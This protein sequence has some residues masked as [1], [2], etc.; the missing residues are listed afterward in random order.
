M[1]ILCFGTL[2]YIAGT[3]FHPE[4]FFS[5]K[6][7]FNQNVTHNQVTMPKHTLIRLESI[8]MA[9]SITFHTFLRYFFYILKP[10]VKSCWTKTWCYNW[11]HI[12]RIT[13]FIT[14]NTMYLMWLQYQLMYHKTTYP[15]PWAEGDGKFA[16]PA[17][18][19]QL[20]T[21]ISEGRRR[22]KQQTIRLHGTK[23]QG[24]ILRLRERLLGQRHHDILGLVKWQC[25]RSCIKHRPKCQHRHQCLTL[26]QC[27]T[28]TVSLSLYLATGDITMFIAVN[29]IKYNYIYRVHFYTHNCLPTIF[30][31]N[32]TLFASLRWLYSCQ[33]N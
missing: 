10:S 21:V 30:L 6:L 3:Y 13:K 29:W 12:T 16:R 15:R 4:S 26:Q 22:Q 14:K 8:L 27:I 7:V 32:K 33:M 18:Q 19:E 5:P 2:L 17:S 28:S 11:A 20:Q 9:N 31:V 1:H 23:P 24:N 25:R